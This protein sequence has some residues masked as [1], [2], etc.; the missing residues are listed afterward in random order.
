MLFNC[1][2]DTE[3]LAVPLAGFL[4]IGNVFTLAVCSDAMRSLCCNAVRVINFAALGVDRITFQRLLRSSLTQ[5]SASICEIN[6]CFCQW[7]SGAELRAL[8]NL[9]S[10]HTLNLDGCQSVDDDD[11]LFLAQR[12]QK[13]R[14]F[15]LYWNVKV[16]DKGVCQILRAQTGQLSALN[17]SGCKHLSDESVQRLVS[18]AQQLEIL[19]LTRC[20]RVTEVGVRL[21]CECLDRLRVLRLY[22][23]AQLPPSAFGSLCRLVELEELDLCGCRIEEDA[24]VRVLEVAP[25]LH[26]LNLTWCPAL[27][28]ATVESIARNCHQVKWLSLFGNTNIS[29]AAIEVLAASPCAHVMHSLDIRGL[30][31]ASEYAHSKNLRGLFPVLKHTEL[32]H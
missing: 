8:P 10:L 22:A 26:T 16:T 3:T 11:L 12:C 24:L 2:A 27:T 5:F 23:M 20:P 7:L 14:S 28:D 4:G 32:H 17:F 6:A 29:N 19:D 13:L 9:P 21:V 30:T 25:K 1:V 18:R 31:L 15:S